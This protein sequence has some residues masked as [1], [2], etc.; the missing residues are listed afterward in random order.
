MVQQLTDLLGYKVFVEEYI[1]KSWSLNLN[2]RYVPICIHDNSQQIYLHCQYVVP[3]T[4]F[5]K[6]L[7]TVTCLAQNNEHSSKSLAVSAQ[8]NAR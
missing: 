5:K 6:Y 4:F 2:L 3:I 1:D 8:I 7:F